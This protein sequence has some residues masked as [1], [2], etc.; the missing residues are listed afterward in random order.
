MYHHN[1][2]LTGI[3]VKYGTFL[4]SFYSPET[5]YSQDEHSYPHTFPLRGGF[6]LLTNRRVSAIISTLCKTPVGCADPVP[7]VTPDQIRGIS[8]SDYPQHFTTWVT[9]K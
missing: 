9:L 2:V 6:I 5:A 3:K 8:L 7:A 1:G 4:P